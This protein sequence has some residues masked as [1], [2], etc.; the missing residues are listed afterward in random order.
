MAIGNLSFFLKIKVKL[1]QT[2]IEK[3]FGIHL[4][5][6]LTQNSF[7]FFS[8]SFILLSPQPQTVFFEREIYGGT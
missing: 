5:T 7:Y 3:W 6:D 4:W 2:T 1:T 8:Q